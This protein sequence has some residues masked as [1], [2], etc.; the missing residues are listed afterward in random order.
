MP[1]VAEGDF[2]WGSAKAESNLEKHGVSFPEAAKVF[3][4]RARSARSDHQRAHRD[5]Q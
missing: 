2:E 1:T 3:A 4:D 5:R